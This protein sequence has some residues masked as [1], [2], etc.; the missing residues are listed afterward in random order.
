MNFNPFAR[1]PMPRNSDRPEASSRILL[2]AADIAFREWSASALRKAGYCAEG[3]CDAEEAWE[4]L[5]RHGYELLVVEHKLPGRS[6]LRLVL[7]MNHANLTLPVVLVTEAP[8]TFDR[9]SHRLLRSVT[10]LPRPFGADRLIEIV[11][12]SLRSAQPA[13]HVQRPLPV[14]EDGTNSPRHARGAASTHR[15]TKTALR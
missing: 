4:A 2:V 5:R 12:M 8:V 1:T 9:R 13:K 10:V 3:A 7:R 6:G 15:Q 11:L 14:I